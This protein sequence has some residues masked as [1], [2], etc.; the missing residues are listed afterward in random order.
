[1]DIYYP[2]DSLGKANTH[3]VP[4]TNRLFMSSA[5]RKQKEVLWEGDDMSAW[6]TASLSLLHPL[7]RVVQIQA[8]G[9]LKN[10]GE[11]AC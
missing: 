3:L 9:A 7:L 1:M 2:L 10:I 5:A 6:N 8:S 11:E 4:R